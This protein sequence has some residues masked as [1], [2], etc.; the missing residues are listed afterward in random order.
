[1]NKLRIERSPQLVY[2]DGYKY[3]LQQPHWVQ[4]P[5]RPEKYVSNGWVGLDTDGKMIFM[6]GYAWDGASGPMPD[7]PCAMAGSLMHDGGYQ[8]L[9]EK[10][11]P[12]SDRIVL[13]KFLYD[14]MCND[15]MWKIFAK[16]AYWM[17]RMCGRRFTVKP[18]RIITVSTL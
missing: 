2:K 16:L 13:D 4:T 18:T 7:F 17:V 11:L 15:G 5:L 3:Q 12:Q 10:L 6:P 9:R 14:I 1:M 8:L